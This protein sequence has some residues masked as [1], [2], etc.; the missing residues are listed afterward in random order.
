MKLVVIA[1]LAAM[2]LSVLGCE[3][4]KPEVKPTPAATA[5]AAPAPAG[6]SAKPTGGGWLASAGAR[7]SVRAWAAFASLAGAFWALVA[8]GCSS[9]RRAGD[10]PAA[11]DPLAPLV[12]FEEGRRA[13][14]DFAH[15]PPSDHAFGP[16][17]MAIRPLRAGG[18]VARYAGIL[19]G[20]D[21]LVLLDASLAEI[22]RA[23]SPPS[24]TGL[25]IGEG[26]DIFV[27]GDQSNEIWRYRVE[28]DA[29]LRSERLTIEGARG[30]RDVAEAGGVLYA[31]DEREG[32]LYA[33]GAGV[34][35]QRRVL[36][37]GRGPFR[38]ER[39]GEWL[40]VDC[41]LDHTIVVYRV[42][43]R[44]L[45]LDNGAITIRHDGPLWGFS[46]LASGGALFVAAGGVEDHPLD[47]TGGSFGF[48]DSFAFLYRIAPGADRAERLA[49][50][51]V[52]AE[53]VITPKALLLR[54]QGVGL[55]ATVTGFGGDRALAIVWGDEL[56]TPPR[57][58]ASPSPPG[59]AMMAEAEKGEAVFA[60]PL[61]DAWGKLPLDPPA[62]P[63]LSPA[64]EPEPAP[65][66]STAS[67]VGEALFFTR[68]MAPWNHSDDRL[69]RFTC[70]T[71]H[72]E[73]Y[74]DG[75]VHHTGRDDVRVS[76]K[77][78]LGLF[79]NRPHFS[80]ALDPG[81]TAVADNEFRV[82][83]ALSGHDPWFSAPTGELPWVS[84]LGAPEQELGPEGLRMALMS[85]LMEFTHRPN[86]S[87]LNRA[88]SFTPL[89][90]EGAATFGRRCERCH[91]A[92]L[93][94][95]VEASRVPFERW[96]ALVMSREG[97]IVWG[98][99]GYEKTGVLPYVHD[100]GA[101]VPSLRRLYKKWPYL[102]NGSAADL[103]AV[104]DGVRFGGGEGAPVFYH[105][106]TPPEAGLAELG[107]SEKAALLAYLDLL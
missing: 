65:P 21:A 104:L 36:S 42:D 91:A 66:R 60:D 46:A 84:Q 102:T 59:I 64:H 32:R 52:A 86:P 87:V 97:P 98:R 82:A 27:S 6:A 90:R 1:A 31:V 73:G 70:E 49:A 67:K 35:G 55:S 103:R 12:A 41:L 45:P 24:P 44:G 58:V 75:R 99:S 61:F 83:G 34:A 71:C 96:E 78:L 19:R 47:R 25:A 72:F 16:D 33:L 51:N 79:N 95:D 92:R 10:E 80:R 48:I 106:G 26:G 100:Q 63:S 15:L 89:E 74:V 81:L 39:E 3:E 107:E 94:T 29:P 54:A 8:P 2:S 101:R 11:A 38:V 85:F 76:T 22:A 37:P 68:L 88:P 28:N 7:A 14:V 62:A 13:S 56:T 105:Q 4:K 93:A 20:R 57:L 40:V 30:L 17:P 5:T 43:A 69:S 50:I 23:P 18:G 9:S 53:G 77:P